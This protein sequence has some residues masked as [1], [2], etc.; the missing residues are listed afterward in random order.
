LQGKNAGHDKNAQIRDVHG[1]IFCDPTRPDPNADHKHEQFIIT[2]KVEF[3]K[4][5]INIPHVVIVNKIA[6]ELKAYH[7]RTRFTYM[8]FDSVTRSATLGLPLDPPL[9]PQ[10]Q[11]RHH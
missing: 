1:S 9:C 3:W 7:P 4:H 11:I 5:S 2:P 6:F 8:L 10:P